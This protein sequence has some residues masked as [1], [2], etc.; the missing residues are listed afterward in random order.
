MHQPAAI[1]PS[2]RAINISF[3]PGIQVGVNS[4]MLNC[5]IGERSD[6]DLF[7][8]HYLRA[9]SESLKVLKFSNSILELS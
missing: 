9:V 5:V 7:G 2:P 6:G 1:A 4:R 3:E 8:R